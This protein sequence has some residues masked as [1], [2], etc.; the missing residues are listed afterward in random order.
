VHPAKREVRFKSPQAVRA[1]VISC[2]RAAIDQMGQAVS[3]TT[4]DQAMRSMQYD[5]SGASSPAMGHGGMPRFSSGDF[6]GSSSTSVPRDVQR[7]L[8]SRPGAAEPS[9]DY[10]AGDSLNLGHPLA[11]IHRCYIL[12]QT[13]SGVILVDQHAADERMTYEKLKNQL[14]G[15]QVSSQKLLTPEPLHLSGETAAWLHDHHEQ[16]FPFGVELEITG[17]ESFRVC[18]VPAMLVREPAA[19]L[20]SELVESCMLMGAV[21]EGDG[22]GLGRILERWLGN[23]ACKGSIK[24]GRLLSHEEQESLL[25]KMEQT[26]NI[27]QC[28]HGRP[29]YVTLTLNDLDR[30]FGR[31]D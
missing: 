16:L 25:R 20:V 28:N 3:S 14:A 4:T 19:E 1:G 22:R 26:P 5:G 2:I 27:A 8:F 17:D 7:M 10:G 23:R 31:K 18:A 29:T 9:V 21:A 15:R 6:R 11:Q 30:L 12:A 24:S 13:E